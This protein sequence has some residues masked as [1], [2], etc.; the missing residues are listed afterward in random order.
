M[1]VINL[2]FD[3][4]KNTISV[5]TKAKGDGLSESFRI[6]EDTFSNLFAG[7]YC[8]GYLSVSQDGPV[9]I[10]EREGA[11][12]VI[13]QRG[14]R[15]NQPITWAG[16]STNIAS[17]WTFFGFKLAPAN[18]GFTRSRECIAVSDG[19]CRGA[20]SQ[21]YSAEFMGNVY[22]G[23]LSSVSTSN[24]NICWG[25]TAVAPGGVVSMASL[26]NIANDFFV[27]PF[28]S[29]LEP[30]LARWEEFA[31]TNTIPSP[32]WGTLNEMIEQLWK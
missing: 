3:S 19:P 15:L 14:F 16:R 8:T 7:R 22:R 32:R 28:T 2:E 17:P 29:H 20:V 30:S 13:V 6:T 21:I 26:T 31:K 9:Y 1:A 24:T 5:K 23:G 11:R 10:E 18:N 27:Q 25:N 12:V 4:D